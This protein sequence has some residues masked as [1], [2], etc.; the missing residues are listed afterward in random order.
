MQ[1]ERERVQ[2][3]KPMPGVAMLSRRAHALP[4]IVVTHRAKDGFSLDM[5]GKF[6]ILSGKYMLLFVTRLCVFQL[7][8]AARADGN[9]GL[10]C[11]ADKSSTSA[12]LCAGKS[13]T[14]QQTGA[15]SEQ[16]CIVTQP[17]HPS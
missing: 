13:R 5:H 10:S 4:F 11:P 2:S 3:N 9:G 15:P 14:R 1:K 8:V 6:C 12:R 17:V 16:S 7:E